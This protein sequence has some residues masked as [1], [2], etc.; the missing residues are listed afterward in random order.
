MKKLIIALLIVVVGCTAVFAGDLSLGVA[1]N[2]MDTYFLADYQGNH[3]GVEG[4]VGIPLIYGTAA[5]IEN[6]ADGKD[7]TIGDGAAMVLLPAA[8]VNGYW[9]AIDGKVFDLRLGIQADVFSIF[10]PDFK[11]VFGLWGTSIGLDFTFSDRFSINL[12][13]TV[14]AALPLSVIGEDATNFGA[15]LFYDSENPDIGDFFAIFFGQMLPGM[16]SEMARLSFKWKV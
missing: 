13:G 15:F 14:P 7:V 11:S 10:T 16:L 9:K 5:L 8:M 4:G 12:T 1:Q 2:F 6:I 3:F